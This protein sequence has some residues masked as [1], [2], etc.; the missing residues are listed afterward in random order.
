[1]A[2]SAVRDYYQVLGVPRTANDK[3][4]KSAYRRLA[5]KYHPDLNPG[6]K[7]AEARF[8]E[9]QSAYDVLSDPEKRKKYDQFGPNWENL[10]RAQGAGGFANRTRTRTPFDFDQ[11]GGGDFS[12]LF[13]NL[14]GGLGGSGSRTRTGFRPRARPG[15]DTDHSI[16]VSLEEAFQGTTRVLEFPARAG[17][18][19]RRLEVKVP[20]GIKTGAKIRISGEG[21]AG[22]GGG[23]SGDLYLV[24]NV[25]PHGAFE[26]KDDDVSSEVNLPLTTAMLGGEVQVPTLNGKSYRL[27]IP[28]ETQN[29]QSFRMSGLGMPKAGGGFGDLYVRARIVLPTRLTPAERQLFEELQR[30]RGGS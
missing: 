4:I 27:R 22:I 9:L 1:M 26:R 20:A 21:E 7:S 12:D 13:E 16:E 25:R 30:L 5:R 29:G 15:Q 18:T 19:P 2:S 11:S 10:E 6:D 24:V 23:P 28:A 17:G 8:K 3:E 14:F